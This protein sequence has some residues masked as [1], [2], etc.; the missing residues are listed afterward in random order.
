M[1][2][3]E[4]RVALNSIDQRVTEIKKRKVLQVK[5]KRPRVERGM[6]LLAHLRI[7]S[8]RT[9]NDVRGTLALAERAETVTAEA[10]VQYFLHCLPEYLHFLSLCC[11][12][13]RI[14]AAAGIA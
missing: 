13:S 3:A 4:K 6:K 9:F 1:V 14:F 10:L 8:K 12:A 7:N 11:F 5:V 2:T